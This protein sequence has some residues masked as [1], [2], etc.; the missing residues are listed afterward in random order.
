MIHNDHQLRTVPVYLFE[1]APAQR[2]NSHS[3]KKA[4]GYLR[5]RRQVHVR[6]PRRRITVT[7]FRNFWH[8]E[9]TQHMSLSTVL[10]E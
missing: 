1:E 3:R 2:R 9:R 5:R 10:D 7:Y 6:A 4:A 8:I